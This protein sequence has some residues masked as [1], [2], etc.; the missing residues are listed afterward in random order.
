MKNI[1]NVY[2]AFGEITKC[3]DDSAGFDSVTEMQKTAALRGHSYHGAIQNKWL[4][5][6]YTKLETEMKKLTKLFDPQDREDALKFYDDLDCEKMIST[7]GL[8]GVITVF[9]IG[10][11]ICTK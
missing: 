4:K 7:N 3:I 10:E 8:T 11:L 5:Y 2:G 9:F 6:F 1:K